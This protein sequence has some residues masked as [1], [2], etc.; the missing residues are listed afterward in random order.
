VTRRTD[1]FIS[2]SKPHAVGRVSLIRQGIPSSSLN[3]R[4]LPVGRSGARIRASRAT[5]DECDFVKL[6][7]KV[8]G[9]Q[10][11]AV[12]L[13]LQAGQGIPRTSAASWAAVAVTGG[14][15]RC[16]GATDASTDPNDRG[17]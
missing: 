2:S 16:V 6:V 11:P 8:L 3:V 17:P 9:A 15:S 5:G 12:E 10:L 13:A 14:E 4:R 1:C 7:V